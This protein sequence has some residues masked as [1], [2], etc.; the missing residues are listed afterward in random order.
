MAQLSVPYMRAVLEELYPGPKVRRMT[1]LQIVAV[2]NRIK[3][4]PVRGVGSQKFKPD[5]GPQDRE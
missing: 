2:Y 5:Y 1:D 4:K 3:N